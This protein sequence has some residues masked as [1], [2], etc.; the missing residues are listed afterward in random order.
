MD[1]SPT[2]ALRPGIARGAYPEREHPRRS[3][4]DRLAHVLRGDLGRS[5]GS[6]RLSE[7]AASVHI[8]GAGLDSAADSVLCE[9]LRALRR[10]LIQQ[11]P[12]DA[13]LP[14]AFAL[15]REVARRS[16]GVVPYD[17]QLM[18]GWVM[19]RGMLAE[20]ETGEG[21]TLTATLPAA[22]AALASIPVHVV[23]VNDYL[24]ERDAKEM[25]PL[26][27]AL[28]LTV[29][30]LTEKVRD[31][32][33]RR[34]AYACDVTYVTGRQLAFDYLR[35]GLSGRR[36]QSSSGPSQA[37][38]DGRGAPLLRGLCFAIVD[39]VDS[40]L[41]DEARTP[42]ILAGSSRRGGQEEVYDQA[43]DLARD[44]REGIDF[45]ARVHE[46]RVELSARGRERLYEK[47]G[48]LGGFWAGPR[49][50]EEW[51]CKA[52]TALHLFQREHH[53]L[54]RDGRVEIIDQP[55]G[56]AAPDRSWE[57]GLHQLIERKEGCQVSAERETLAR[58]STQQFFRRFLR[59]AG[60]T[61]T[62]R[63]V[64]R[65]LWSV[66]GL[67]TVR[68]PTHRPLRR[69]T[70]GSRVLGDASEK[71]DAVVARVA[72]LHGVGRPVLVGTST[73]AASEALSA[74]L[75]KAE[76][77]HQVLN[78]RQDAQEAAVVAEAGGPG[79]ITVATAMAG[80]GTDIRLGA[81]VVEAGGLHVI[82]TQRAEAGRID[83]QLFGRCGRQ[84]DP[85]SYEQVLSMQD[86]PM[87][88]FYPAT[89][90][91]WLTSLARG[92]KPTGSWRR[93]LLEGLTWIPQRAEEHRHRRLRRRLVEIEEYLGDLLAFAGRGE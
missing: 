91:A 73:L 59:L 20:M 28:G 64:A 56:R 2:D 24:V 27:E 7:F 55:T 15:V 47:G 37:R 49:R 57:Q 40:V 45:T 19:A 84:G 60:T 53:Y 88:G 85:G 18:G 44:L 62:A 69:R 80:R 46:G 58:I 63:E 16:L 41:I 77:P 25:G 10:R 4:L 9:S 23:S 66:Y 70:D 92:Q 78:A 22:V 6:K 21:K 11:G 82:A 67:A 61:G 86:A 1:S 38:S 33:A 31:P 75:S 68:I 81:G 13:L 42:L 8:S 14:P 74:R 48:S 83:R 12:V 30:A 93:R 39:E 50:R 51:A 87:V 5:A 65:E 54:I 89:L 71:W 17:V 43:L 76:L 29:G 32:A 35:D 36:E 90:L 52:L 79:R 72:E 26:Y 34:A 3:R